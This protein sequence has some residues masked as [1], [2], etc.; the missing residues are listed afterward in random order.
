MQID[1]LIIG[2]GMAGLGAA[3][4]LNK[5]SKQTLILEASNNVGGLN[6]SMVVCGCNFDIGPKI[7]LLDDSKNSKEILNYLDGNYEKYPVIE[8]VYISKYGFVGF[9]LQRHLVDLPYE[10]RQEM[11]KSFREAQ[12]NPRGVKCFKDWLYNGFG[13]KFCEEILYPYEEKKWQIDLRKMDYTW[14]LE[15]PIKVD[16]SVVETGAVEKLPPQR[17]YYYPK[18]GSIEVLTRNMSREAGAIVLNSKVEY[19]NTRKKYIKDSN[20]NIFRYKRL[21]STIP[22]D[23][24]IRMCSPKTC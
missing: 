15:R 6:T 20:G 23:S 17:Y 21:I 7:L 18:Y 22:L 9:P 24:F 12:K 11:L 2:S 8:K 16:T 3:I 14:A 10:A 13:K 19:V 1:N 4:K 5:K